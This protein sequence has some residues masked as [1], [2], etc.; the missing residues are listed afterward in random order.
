MGLRVIKIEPCFW[1]HLIDQFKSFSTESLNFWDIPYKRNGFSLF[2]RW[3]STAKFV[4]CQSFVIG[5]K[6]LSYMALNQLVSEAHA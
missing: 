4:K 1:C 3:E 5:D 6:I 2:Q